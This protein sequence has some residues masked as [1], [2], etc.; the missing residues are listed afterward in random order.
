MGVQVTIRPHIV[1]TTKFDQF[2]IL[3]G[4][5]VVG[6]KASQPGLPPKLVVGN[7]PEDAVNAVAEA[8]RK[9]DEEINKAAVTTKP[10][11][12][13]TLSVAHP[14]GAEPPQDPPAPPA[15]PTDSAELEASLAA[16]NAEPPQ[17][18]PAK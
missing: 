9:M 17:D 7:L 12:A 13:P 1:G 14:I 6:Y 5:R 10:Q 2:Q 15:D 4:Q 16:H 18:P 3:I 11:L 8:C